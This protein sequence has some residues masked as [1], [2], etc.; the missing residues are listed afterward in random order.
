MKTLKEKFTFY[1]NL[2]L[3]IEKCIR[4]LEILDVSWDYT[5]DQLKEFNFKKNYWINYYNIVNEFDNLANIVN[6]EI[7]LI[8]SEFVREELKKD[9]EEQN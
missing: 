4:D 2:L 5:K 9:E 1:N 8:K 3:R 6:T 7:F